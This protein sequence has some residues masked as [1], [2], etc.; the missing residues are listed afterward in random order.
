MSGPER[1]SIRYIREKGKELDVLTN[2]WFAASANPQMDNAEAS[3]NLA[4]C[5][6]EVGSSFKVLG[7]AVGVINRA[8]NRIQHL[9]YFPH[10]KS[11]TPI[12]PYPSAID[13]DQ[14][15]RAIRSVVLESEKGNA[16]WINQLFEVRRKQQ[17]APDAEASQI[18]SEQ[19]IVCVTPS[20]ISE[21]LQQW[22]DALALALYLRN[23]HPEIDFVTARL[24][25]VESALGT[26]LKTLIKTPQWTR[27]EDY[28]TLI[29]CIDNLVSNPAFQKQWPNSVEAMFFS[30][31]EGSERLRL[32]LGKLKLSDLRNLLG[33]RQSENCPED[34][35]LGQLLYAYHKRGL[36]VIE[37]LVLF[38]L[39]GVNNKIY[40]VVWPLL[41]TNAYQTARDR[42]QLRFPGVMLLT[43]RTELSEE[44]DY[45]KV[46]DFLN[47][48]ALL[49]RVGLEPM[50]DT[51]FHGEIFK[52][53]AVE[54][55][56][57]LNLLATSHELKD[58]VGLIPL[59][60]GKPFVLR[61]LRD[62]LLTISL[63]AAGKVKEE[64]GGR[65]LCEEVRGGVE[66]PETGELHLYKN[67]HEWLSALLALACRIAAI[68][69]VGVKG[70]LPQTE[71]E[72]V[73]WQNILRAPFQLSDHL[74]EITCPASF[75]PRCF[76]AVAILCVFRNVLKHCFE[77]D[78][79]RPAPGVREIKW[80]MKING[81]IEVNA[82]F[83][84]DV[85]VLEVKNPCLDDTTFYR[86]KSTKGTFLAVDYFLS[87]I[88][89]LSEKR[90]LCKMH[91]QTGSFTFCMPLLVGSKV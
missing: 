67:Y 79:K 50:I 83:K 64:F 19:S 22:I 48:F 3:K 78:V 45:E 46:V 73:E 31:N 75:E 60:N 18:T 36:P 85:P 10:D 76:A 72:L 87:Q 35:T 56:K 13:P 65:M 33:G 38:L 5:L 14:V 51:V 69:K 29:E 88:P 12:F 80:L 32:L 90:K 57:T 23:Y 77:V 55:E 86:E 1:I 26:D 24:R 68:S 54:E 6:N 43:L 49:M 84:D 27:F 71:H 25:N 70:V 41:K 2:R 17:N 30:G 40:H 21:I 8:T 61:A 47:P 82:I 66:D 4:Y 11:Q 62:M 59:A 74:R 15:I 34:F 42:S 53:T 58:L 16:D 44:W 28:T 91:P 37:Y 9:K 39:W 81:V 20:E 7:G 63:P 89:E 52:T